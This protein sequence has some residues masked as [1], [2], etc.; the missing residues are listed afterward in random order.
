MYDRHHPIL[1]IGTTSEAIAGESDL[2]CL[3]DTTIAEV[4]ISTLDCI[5]LPECMDISTLFEHTEIIHFLKELDRQQTIFA[6]ISSSVYLLD[7]AGILRERRYTVGLQKEQRDKQ[8]CFNEN[9]YLD[10]LVVRDGNIITAKGRGFI[11]IGIAVG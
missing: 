2:T 10:Q 8:G 3:A 9:N 1:T 4:E 5:I 7:K 11:D 6:S